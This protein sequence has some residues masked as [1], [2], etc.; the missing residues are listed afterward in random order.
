MENLLSEWTLGE[1]WNCKV[2]TETIEP[3]NESELGQSTPIQPRRQQNSPYTPEAGSSV[4]T[5][6]KRQHEASQ[7]NATTSDWVECTWPKTLPPRGLTGYPGRPGHPGPS[8][9]T[10]RHE[11]LRIGALVVLGGTLLFSFIALAPW[12]QVTV[13]YDSCQ[14]ESASWL[15][16]RFFINIV[17]VEGLTFTQAKLLDLAWDTFIGKGLGFLHA[18]WLYQIVTHALTYLLEVSALPYKLLLELSF[19][20][21]SLFAFYQAPKTLHRTERRREKLILAWLVFAIGYVVA[22]PTLWA[23][24]TGY[25]SPSIT[26]YN[27]NSKAYVPIESEDLRLCYQVNDT[28]LNGLVDNNIVLGPSFNELY[29]FN[30]DH[31]PKPYDAWNFTDKRYSTFESL[32]TYGKTKNSLLHFLIGNYGPSNETQLLSQAELPSKDP[33]LPHS[34]S[35]NASSIYIEEGWEDLKFFYA[36]NHSIPWASP[37]LAPVLQGLQYVLSPERLVDARFFFNQSSLDISKHNSTISGTIPYNSTLFLENTTVSL[38]ASFLEFG[39]ASNCTDWWDATTGVCPCY[40]GSPLPEDWAIDP[41]WSCIG[42][43]SNIWGFSSSILLTALILEVV[44]LLSNR[45]LQWRM[46]AHSRLIQ[47]NRRNHGMIRHVL[48]LA[49][50]I[51]R[52]LGPNTCSYIDR[53]LDY[54]LTQCSPVGYELQEQDGLKHLALVTRPHGNLPKPEMELSFRDVFA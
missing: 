33:L 40:L 6:R 25:S 51:N 54:A 35:W 22:F 48:D 7:T 27:L 23:A 31:V 46:A 11:F 8:R 29:A 10:S 1:A 3:A 47:H 26:A 16:S 50:T 4:Q 44:W 19:R 12:L 13:A 42:T 39:R 52:D 30:I 15:E 37:G 34:T 41:E 21:E 38:D 9:N 5:L 2:P 14:A 43:Q 49:E 32:F 45:I 24:A 17:V 28:R 36:S 20:T 18:W 53:D